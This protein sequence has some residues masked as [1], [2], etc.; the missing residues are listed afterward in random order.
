MLN[1]LAGILILLIASAVLVSSLGC[2]N[3]LTRNPVPESYSDSVDIFGD[4]LIRAWGDEYSPE[5]Q[6]DI[7]STAMVEN[8][9]DYP[10]KKPGCEVGYTA[11]AISG[12]GASGAFGAGI[13]DGWSERGDRP[14]FNLVTGISTALL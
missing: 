2:A 11:L 7:I 13:L 4:P 9:S 12:G 8:K 14:K 10:P 3:K 6:E 5:F 1:R